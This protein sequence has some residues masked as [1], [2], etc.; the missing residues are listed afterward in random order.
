MAT[1]W[2]AGVTG[3]GYRG[4]H[5]H[6]RIEYGAGSSVLPLREK[7]LCG[8]DRL[9]GVERGGAS[10]RRR[11][12]FGVL[13]GRGRRPAPALAAADGERPAVR[14]RGEGLL[15]RLGRFRVGEVERQSQEQLSGYR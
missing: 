12:D 5:P 14:R 3:V 9:A 6:P 2:L 10:C 4:L 7:V 11:G 13:A 15:V 1:G 8:V